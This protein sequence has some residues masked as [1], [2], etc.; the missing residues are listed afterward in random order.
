MSLLSLVCGVASQELFAH[1]ISS[2][3]DLCGAR[4]P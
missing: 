2:H 1:N 3:L 4:D